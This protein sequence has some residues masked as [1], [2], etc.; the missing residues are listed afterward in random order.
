MFKLE[1]SDENLEASLTCPFCDTT[2]DWPFGGRML[3]YQP[4]NQ[5][6]FPDGRHVIYSHYIGDENL[7]KFGF[8]RCPR[9]SRWT[10]TQWQTV[11]TDRQVVVEKGAVI[12]TE[13]YPTVTSNSSN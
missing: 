7:E 5:Q 3:W 13:G 11:D 1:I 2:Y 9:V 6:P 12:V 4:E 10:D 8:P